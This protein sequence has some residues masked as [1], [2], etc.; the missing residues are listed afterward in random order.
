LNF[1]SGYFTIPQNLGEKTATDCFSAVDGNDGAATIRVTQ[2]MVAS[3]DAD[4][5]KA[6]AAKRFDELNAREQRKTTHD[7]TVIR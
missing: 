7:F 4:H 3:L 1:C 6:E 5:F 2:E